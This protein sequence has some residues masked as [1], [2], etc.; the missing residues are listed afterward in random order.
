[1]EV[2]VNQDRFTALQPEQARLHL[3]KRKAKKK[4]K[5][6]NRISMNYLGFLI[7]DQFFSLILYKQAHMPFKFLVKKEVQYLK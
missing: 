7:L 4:E 1:M 2:A 5:N 6:D 3:K